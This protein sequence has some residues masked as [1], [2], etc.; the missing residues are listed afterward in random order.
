MMKRRILF[1]IILFS[2]YLTAAQETV[3]LELCTSKAIENYPLTKQTELLPESHDLKISNLNKNYLPQMNLNGQAHYQSDVTK[4]PVQNIPGI[5]IP[6]V[7]KDW[8]KLTFDVNQVIFDGSATGRQKDVEDISLEIDQQA[9]QV[10]LYKLKERINQIYFNVLLVKENKKVLQLYY[11]NLTSKLKDLESGVKNGTIL[12]SNADV[13]SAEMIK[14]E[15]ALAETGITLSSFIAMLNEF[16]GFNL[17]ENTMFILPDVEILSGEY[18]NNRP[19]YSL[20]SLQQNKID[21]SKKLLGSGTLPRLSAFG[22]AGYGRPGYDM[23]KNDFDDFYMIGAGLNWKFW[24]WNHT[25]KEKEILSL[26]NEIINTQKETFDKNVKIDLENKIA[27]INKAEELIIR[28][29]EL[30][31]LREKISKS[32]S[33][34]L[35]NGVI[36]SSQYLTEINAEA[37][38]KLDLESHKIQLVKAKLDYQAALGN[39]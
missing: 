7:S 8:Y 24:D 33:S 4:T 34:Q 28:D 18:Q 5:N 11:D 36:T 12:P 25:R 35:D 21:A 31:E 29:K 19:E 6:T 1:L 30:I 15:Q 27:E 37:S 39:L 16:T 17:N 10:E 14:S 22:Q 9:V 32:V 23:L 38:A 3:T 13:L 2:G 26:Q 20:F